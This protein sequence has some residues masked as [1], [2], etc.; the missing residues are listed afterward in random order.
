MSLIALR[1]A[2]AVGVVQRAGEVAVV[3]HEGIAG[4]QDLLGHLVD[5]W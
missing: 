2:F 3:D 5:G 4:P 1:D